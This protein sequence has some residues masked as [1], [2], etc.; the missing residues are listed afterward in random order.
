[1][2]CVEKIYIAG[3]FAKERK[4][5]Q[6]FLNLQRVLYDVSCFYMDFSHMSE[7]RVE[8]MTYRRG[9][10]T[11]EKG[12]F[13]PSIAKHTYIMIFHFLMLIIHKIWVFNVSVSFNKNV[14]LRMKCCILVMGMFCIR[15]AA[16]G[17][18]LG[19]AL[20]LEH[21]VNLLFKVFGLGYLICFYCAVFC[22]F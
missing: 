8:S 1:M 3:I 22:K 13:G 18:T 2:I 4:K 10:R 15:A 9:M 17:Q 11:D 12:Y 5:T 20:L 16:S 7:K 6:L 14:W 19:C 21:R